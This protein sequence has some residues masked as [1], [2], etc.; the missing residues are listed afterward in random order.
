MTSAGGGAT[1]PYDITSVEEVDTRVGRFTLE[2]ETYGFRRKL[3]NVA[4]Q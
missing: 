2:N 4:V 1:T 3:L